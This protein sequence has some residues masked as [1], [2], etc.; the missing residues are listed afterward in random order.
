M[1][2]QSTR[3]DIA[4]MSCATCS[5][6]VQDALSSLSGVETVSVNVAT[7][8]AA[9]THDPTTVSVKQLYDTISSAGYDPLDERASIGIT[10][11]SCSSCAQTVESA[12]ES[13]S[14]VLTADVNAAIDEAQIQ[15]NPAMMARSDL[16][17]IITSAGYTPIA[18][19]S[20]PRNSHD[21]STENNSNDTDINTE[22]DNT[23]A[24]ETARTAEIDRQRRLTIF[25]AVLATPLVGF[26]LA[27]L[28]MPNAI[29]A[30]IPYLDIPFGWVAFALATP[31]QLVL[32]REFYENSYTAVVRNRT[33]NMDV[34]IALGSSTAYL[35][36]VVALLDILPQ[37][38]LYF[39]TAALILVFIT[40]GNYLEARS[41]G[42]A[43]SALRALLEMEADTATIIED[44]T[45]QTIPV[46]DIT[47][48]DQL[49]VRPGEQIPTDGAVIEG[50]S[51][52]DESMVTGE[53]VPVSKSPGDTVVG[54]TV[55]QNGVITIEATK[56]G[57]DTAIQQIVQ[58]VKEAQSRQPDIQQFADRISA[59][60]VPAV[61]I[62][63]VV[64]ALLWF[65]F[66]STLA[67]LTEFIPAIGIIAGG[68]VVA[69]GTVS[70][71]EFAVLVFASAVLIACPCALGLATPAAT[72]VGTT[73]GAKNGILFEGG[74]VLERVRDIDT[75][76]FDKTGTLTTG[77][78]SVTDVIALNPQT[79][80]GQ[81]DS[82]HNSLLDSNTRS[83]GASID[84]DSDADVDAEIKTKTDI[85]PDPDLVRTPR[86]M[87]VLRL[88]AAAEQNS[89][90]PL[91]D[92]IVSAA[93]KCDLN[94]PTATEF[95]A[96]PGQG[97][98]ATV[99]QQTVI[100]GNDRLLKNAGIDIDPAASTLRELESDGKTAML[101][102]V[103]DNPDVSIFDDTDTDTEITDTRRL[104]GVIAD[105]DTIKDSAMDAVETLRARGTTVHLITGDNE[106][107]AKAVAS[108]VGIDPEN[109][110]AEV[111]PE[112]KADAVE[113]IQSAEDS[114]VMMVGDGVNDAP[115]LAAAFVG[116]ALG[117]GTDVAIEAAEVTLMRDS[118]ADV[119]HAIRI[120]EGTLSKIKQNLFW[121]L[122]Y[123]TAMIPLAS[124]GLLQPVLAAGA[125]ALSSVSVL[126]NS[127]LFRGYDPNSRYR[128]LN[129]LRRNK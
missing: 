102:G 96:I 129:S 125:M 97:V 49:R 23:D 88:A 76:V 90:H 118:P 17:D 20:N 121:A 112:A 57:S 12:L 75:V 16:A 46:S 78:M 99:D 71:V 81:L 79:D 51:A 104:V 95:N 64:W 9:V 82:E 11:L 37:A 62:N 110:R 53:S 92:A 93:R 63:A 69:G 124:L 115:A 5:Q 68:P 31:I 83:S 111:L 94:I 29:P 41:K 117:S 116:T 77:E 85:D 4:G 126:T 122:G 40:L 30:T 10:D 6:S 42:Q 100:V 3:I 56:I 1:P 28:F 98:R 32:G 35:Y 44:N 26:L 67:S 36:S 80:G 113:T 103:I 8:E 120:S 13:V 58:T 39:D 105:A 114:R 27:H 34:L 22:S 74:D 70:T 119:V 101:V 43:S 15:Y 123:N 48:G 86:E 55:N 14:G 65:A 2:T 84:T 87:A 109:V 47:V 50:S 45:E 72:M 66:P 7:D 54:S 108:Q 24:R 73:I 18:D 128:F 89:E 61:I 52:V 38:G 127:L 107:T 21:V 60:F 106:R 19:G 59:Y 91:G 33:A 25:G